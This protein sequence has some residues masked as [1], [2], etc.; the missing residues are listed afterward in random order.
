MQGL[1]YGKSIGLA[2]A[3]VLMSGVTLL[4]EGISEP[5]RVAHSA[6]VNSYSTFTTVSY[7][8]GSCGADD[9]AGVVM[10]PRIKKIL[11][12]FI[13]ISEKALHWWFRSQMKLTRYQVILMYKYKFYT[14]PEF[15]LLIV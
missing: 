5:S 15:R 13:Q 4:V 1:H 14:E 10:S 6:R 11:K 2:I 12:V 9:T 8:A 7:D 3:L